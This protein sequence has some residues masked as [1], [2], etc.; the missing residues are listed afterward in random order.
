MNVAIINYNAGNTRS[1]FFAL[2]RLGI[3]SCI[4]DDMKEIRS[5]DKVILP[6]V[7][8]A[9]SAMAY[10]KEKGLDILIKDLEQ[11]VLGI[12]LGM[13]LMCR[14]SEEGKTDCLNIF[15]L[16]V[17]KFTQPG[18]V[19]QIGWN[20]LYNMKGPLF[21]GIPEHSFMYFVHS[22]YIGISGDTIS[23]TQY[24]TLFSSA[25]KKDN[26]YGVQFHPE[27]SGKSGEQIIKNFLTL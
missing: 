16:D 25:F 4:T 14:Y 1:V 19:P 13:Q 18:K 24:A 5:A 9:G 6:G 22:Y 8:E 3:H 21:A 20:T 17:I 2:E 27:K 11:P 15:D 23:E 10:L 7:G 12:C 26:F